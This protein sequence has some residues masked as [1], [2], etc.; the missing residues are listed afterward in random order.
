MILIRNI[1]IEY[2]KLIIVLVFIMI[3]I[4]LISKKRSQIPIF[5][6]KMLSSYMTAVT[7]WF[8]P[9]YTII[10]YIFDSLLLFLILYTLLG[11]MGE[12]GEKRILAYFIYFE[13]IQ[14]LLATML[15]LGSLYNVEA[16]PVYLTT[17]LLIV[18]A[19]GAETAIFLA[20]FMRYFRLTGLTKFMH[21]MKRDMTNTTLEKKTSVKFFP[22]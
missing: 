10:Y 12:Y 3:N 13:L 15:M 11:L 8:M 20:L 6:I 14:L 4:F 16:T 9:E 21:D 2:I 1:Y 18:G 19:S 17:A 5:N 22:Q 7:M